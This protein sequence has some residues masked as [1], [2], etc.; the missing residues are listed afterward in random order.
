MPCDH[1]VQIGWSL[2]GIQQSDKAPTSF[3]TRGLSVDPTGAVLDPT[4]NDSVQLGRVVAY[5]GLLVGAYTPDQF[6]TVV[7][8]TVITCQAYAKNWYVLHSDLDS[9]VGSAWIMCLRMLRHVLIVYNEQCPAKL[10]FALVLVCTLLCGVL[11]VWRC[12]LCL[13]NEN[14]EHHAGT[15]STFG[16]ALCLW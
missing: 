10:Q 15:F 8:G 3:G 6:E 1:E 13:A 2:N 16:T 5:I 11:V 4:A 12:S 9:R 7:P 14:L